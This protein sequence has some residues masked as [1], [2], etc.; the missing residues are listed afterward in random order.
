MRRIRYSLALFLFLFQPLISAQQEQTSRPRTLVF[1]NVSV[2]DVTANDSRRA[3][4][5][6]QTVVVSGGRIT[7]V[8]SKAAIPEGA[9]VVDATGKYL[10]PGLWDMHVHTLRKDRVE[11]FFPLF[12][13]NGVT[14]VRD[15][16]TP[17]ENFE[18]FKQWRREIAE[19]TRLGPRIVA[20]S[21]F[22]D[23]AN[24]VY[25]NVSISVSNE[26]EARR[27][28]RTRDCS[29]AR[30]STQA[31]SACRARLLRTSCVRHTRTRRF[32]KPT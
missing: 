27:A 8:G 25:P 23:G 16:G 31:I 5:L 2:I 20:A 22:V 19:G 32:P 15:M 3:L 7:A 30:D 6:N 24:P 14:G 18:L 17:L 10:I 29:S 21:P 1:R 28:V 9:L 11:T 13:V 12:I 4:R 26:E